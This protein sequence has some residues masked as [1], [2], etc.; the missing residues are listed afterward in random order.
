MHSRTRNTLLALGFDTDLIAKMANN[1]HTVD[2]LRSLSKQALLADYTPGEVDLIQDRIRREPIAEDILTRVV[3]KAGEACCFCA[4]GNSTRPYQIHHANEYARTHD[5]SEE[6]LILVCPTHHQSVPKQ[7]SAEQQKAIRRKWHAVVEIAA[8]YRLRGL[9]FPF[10][11]FVAKDY[12]LEPRPNEMIHGYRLSDATALAASDH[13]LARKGVALLRERGMLP[14]VGASGDG[15]T[16]LAVGI[17]GHLWREGYRIFIYQPPAAGRPLPLQDVLVFMQTAD[18]PCVL[19]LDDANRVFAETDLTQIDAAAGRPV[20]VL[21]TWT[22][23]RLIED[24]KPERHLANWLLV[25]WEQIRPSVKV[26]L[27]AHEA[28]VVAAIQRYQAPREPGRVGLG[29]MDVPLA[30]H[31][32]RYETEAKTVSQFLFLLRGGAHVVQTEIEALADNS[33]SDVPVLYAAIEQIAGFEK[34]VTPEGTASAIQWR[35]DGS[36]LPT[37]TPE[38]VREVFWAQQRRGRMQEVRGA[39]RTVHRDWAA[40]LIGAALASARTRPETVRLLAPNITLNANEPMRL[41]R[42]WSWLW[43]DKQG[44][45]F[46][47]EW[48]ERQQVADWV[49]LVGGAVS[50][51]LEEVG[52]VADRMH[53]LFSRQDWKETVRTA[54]SSHEELLARAVA[55]AGPR[56]WLSLKGLAFALGHACPD[57]ASRIVEHWDTHAAA[58]V[59]ETTHPDYYD[60]A[61]WVISSYSQH[62][63]AWVEQV[64]KSIQWEAISDRLHEVR[65]GDLDAVFQCE[66]LLHRLHIPLRRSM[67]KRLTSVMVDT[68]RNARL[69]DLHVGISVNP[70]WWMMLPA[71]LRQVFAQLSPNS[72]AEDL[73]HSRPRDW[74]SLADLSALIWEFEDPFFADMIDLLDP[75]ALLAAVQTQ[76][77]GHEYE[78][79]CLLWVL[80]RGR[81]ERRQRLASHLYPLVLAACKRSEAERMP[82]LRAFRELDVD[83]GNRMLSETGTDPASLVQDAAE[84]EEQE[85]TRDQDEMIRQLREDV[86][87][88]EAT[89]R[90]YI[91]DLK[92]WRLVELEGN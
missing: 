48:L 3:Q 84:Q 42:L 50:V 72:I 31:I 58:N 37:P 19:I 80:T 22:R 28:D 85:K 57:L 20:L 49:A 87:T 70:F 1:H 45:P 74:R 5:N 90:D 36:R 83:M 81:A 54:F 14:I 53:L 71:D 21:A 69:S 25:N 59:I 56:D 6:N 44:G 66:N 61:W 63:P 82:L 64:G 35:E 92:N 24:P 12:A 33:R 39:Y 77:A 2:A 23:D 73:G 7:L 91:I 27:L 88:L 52:I 62:S 51:G 40:R 34:P 13:E 46:I 41:M 15:K 78:L 26:F 65:R 67:V 30:R 16:S 43:Y 38:W 11:L 76:A 60:T 47:R 86:A 32:Q 17:A 68:V 10:G 75:E 4:D 29:C 79:R 9:D 89:G 55:S 18:R 8:T